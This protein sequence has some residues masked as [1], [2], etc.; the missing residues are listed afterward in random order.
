VVPNMRIFSMPRVDLGE[1]SAQSVSLHADL[2]GSRPRPNRAVDCRNAARQPR[3]CK[4]V[5]VSFSPSSIQLRR[6]IS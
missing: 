6:C 2:S 4:Q 1:I 3:H 5:L